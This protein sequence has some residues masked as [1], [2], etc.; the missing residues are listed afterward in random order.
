MLE[1]KSVPISGVTIW[2]VLSARRRYD[3]QIDECKCR[4][5][6]I[7]SPVTVDKIA[8]PASPGHRMSKEQEAD[9]GRQ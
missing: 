5:R 1:A 6:G 8:G 7:L 4:P 9:I 3:I 2:R